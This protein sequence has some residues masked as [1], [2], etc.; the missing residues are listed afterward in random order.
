M[1]PIDLWPDRAP[2]RRAC[3]QRQT[4]RAVCRLGQ[5]VAGTL[6]PLCAVFERTFWPLAAISCVIALMHSVTA[7]RVSGRC[8]RAGRP[9]RRVLSEARACG[10]APR[11]SRRSAAPGSHRARRRTD[12]RT[13]RRYSSDAAVAARTLCAGLRART[14]TVSATATSAFSNRLLIALGSY[15]ASVPQWCRPWSARLFKSVRRARIG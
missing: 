15:A 10:N 13:N 12:R 6:R 4:C 3:A 2:P 11:F 9:A 1:W 8:E 14:P 7:T 5:I